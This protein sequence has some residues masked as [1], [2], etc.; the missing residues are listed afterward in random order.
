MDICLPVVTQLCSASGIP[1]HCS[2]V[3]P[4]RPVAPRFIL[5]SIDYPQWYHLPAFAGE[6]PLNVKTAGRLPA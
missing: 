1:S 3:R 5:L 6:A 4:S 2:C